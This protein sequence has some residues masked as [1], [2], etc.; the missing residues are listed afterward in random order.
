MVPLRGRGPWRL[1]K[2]LKLPNA[3]TWCLAALVAL[4]GSGGGAR[5]SLYYNWSG[6]QTI[7]DNDPSG[8]AFAF[9]LAGTDVGQIQQVSVSLN[10]SG[11]A[12]GD[13]YAYLTHGSGFAVLLNRVG[14]GSGNPYGYGDSGM[15]LV[16]TSLGATY[17]DIHQ[18]RMVAGYGTHI[19]DGSLWEADGRLNYTDSARNNTLSVMNGL[20]PS[21]SWTL[22]FADRSAADV[23]TL[24]NF[25]VTATAVP[26]P[27]N[28]ALAVFGVLAAAGAAWRG[29][30]ALASGLY[31]SRVWSLRSKVEGWDVR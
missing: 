23:S 17:G 9:N 6:S 10:I 4:G 3:R 12:N 1:S 20:D 19:A 24:L 14:A 25:S 16:L 21:G 5:A 28:V 31:Q 30:R 2:R 8:V 15:N 13:L 18:Y 26:E 11:G 22:F 27:V 29:R 7:P